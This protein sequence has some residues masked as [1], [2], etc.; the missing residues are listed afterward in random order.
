MYTNFKYI[1]DTCIHVYNIMCMIEVWG[2]PY[3]GILGGVSV[4]MMYG[5]TQVANFCPVITET[6]PSTVY[7]N[8]LQV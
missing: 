7:I 1:Q 4:E 5:L 2:A 6:L 8:D 3:I